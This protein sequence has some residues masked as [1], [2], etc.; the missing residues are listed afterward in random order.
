ML[1]SFDIKIQNLS[2]TP[3]STVA[4]V[5]RTDFEDDSACYFDSAPALH[6]ARIGPGRKL[7]MSGFAVFGG[8]SGPRAHSLARIRSLSMDPT[9]FK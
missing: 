2:K 8:F 9:V 4:L 3:A 6:I 1:L 7:V 5:Y